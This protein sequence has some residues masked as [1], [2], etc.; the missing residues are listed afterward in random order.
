MVRGSINYVLQAFG[1][2][3][4]EVRNYRATTVFLESEDFIGLNPEGVYE[5]AQYTAT[6]YINSDGDVIFTGQERK[7]S[8]F[9]DEEDIPGVKDFMF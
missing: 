9:I 5:G 6:N 2:E 4:R 7:R 1:G 8:V 3:E